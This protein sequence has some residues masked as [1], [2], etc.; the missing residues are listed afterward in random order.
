MRKF[1][2]IHIPPLS[3]FSKKLY[4]DVAL[5]WRGIN[6]LYL[7]LLLAVCWT[8]ILIKMNNSITKFIDNEVPPFVKQVPKITIVNGEV[9]IDKPQPYYIKTLDG[10]N[11]LAII[12]T[13]GTTTSLENT[14]AYILLTKNTIIVRQSDVDTRKYSLS[15]VKDFT[16]TSERL[17]GWICVFKKVFIIV[18]YPM[19]VIGSFVYRLI[20]ALVYGAI[21]ILFAIKLA[22]DA[23]IRLSVVAVT[24][25]IIIN[26]VLMFADV[27]LPVRA[28]IYFLLTMIYLF[29]GIKAIA[30]E[31]TRQQ[32]QSLPTI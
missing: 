31:I 5:N 10:N 21:G 6:F 32:N 18:M 1:S 19:M 15:Q 29:F 11:I 17:M 12:D 4:S 8:F 7:L 9:S 16:L 14:D 30:E 24:P 22:Y 25:C 23:L 20:Q 27:Q 13:T 3:F 26:T 28:L 2:I